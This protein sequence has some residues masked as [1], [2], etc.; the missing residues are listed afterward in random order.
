M[1]IA[2]PLYSFYKA[3]RAKNSSFTKAAAFRRDY[4]AFLERSGGGE[5]LGSKLKIR[6][7]LEESRAESAT[8]IQHYTQ[9]DLHVAQQV[10]QLA[11]KRHVDIGSSIN[12]F[13]HHVAA[14]R[15]IE[16]FDIRPLNY[17]F[18]NVKFTKMNLMDADAVVDMKNCTDS[19]SCLHTLEHFGLGRYGDPIDPDGHKKGFS[20][21]S[22]M[23]QSGGVLFLSVPLGRPKIDFNTH[24]IFS[25]D[26]VKQLYREEFDLE[27]FAYEDDVLGFYQDLN[28]VEAE[29][30]D[31]NQFNFACGIFKL[32]KC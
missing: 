23:V 31:F 29:Q 22:S 7:I 9:Q 17:Q 20:V 2:S 13:V 8:M 15:E 3:L 24:R 4:E 26:Q 5:T 21:L 25:F 32:R 11:P 28:S 19:L 1:Q 6:P 14:F 12:G 18:K 27:A 30:I 10:F 16:V